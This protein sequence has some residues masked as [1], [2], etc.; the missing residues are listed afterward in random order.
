MDINEI[1]SLKKRVVNEFERRK[2]EIEH[3]MQKQ[4]EAI[5][6]VAK[7]LGEDGGGHAQGEANKLDAPE[8]AKAEPIEDKRVVASQDAVIGMMDACGQRFSKHDAEKVCEEKYP[9]LVISRNSWHNA[10][11]KKKLGGQIIEV[12][13]SSGRLPA[14]YEKTEKYKPRNKG[15]GLFEEANVSNGLM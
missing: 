8:Q 15:F 5:E 11:N 3:E 9:H 4:L 7:M 10:V 12:T 2:T 13:K 1:E 6:I 14:V